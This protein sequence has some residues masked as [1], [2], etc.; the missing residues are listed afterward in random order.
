MNSR[1]HESIS[2]PVDAF[3]QMFEPHH[4]QLQTL[5]RYDRYKMPHESRETWVRLLGPDVVSADHPIL[6]AQITFQFTDY[7][8]AHGI[9]LTKD[10]KVLFFTTP[11]VHDTGEIKLEHIGVG[12]TSYDQKT[13]TDEQ[14][15]LDVFAA[16]TQSI[17]NEQTRELIHRAYYEVAMDR[18]TKLGKM[19][20]A[21][22]KIGYL[23]TAI[24]AYEGIQGERVSNWKG[25]VGNVLSNQV[26]KLL[27]Y[28][29]EYPYV[30]HMLQEHA[31]QITRML[32][33]TTDLPTV[34]LDKDGNP[35]FDRTKLIKAQLAW[36]KR[37]TSRTVYTSGVSA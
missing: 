29:N 18:N 14:V 24:R 10:E 37:D 4:K 15:E 27:D 13:Q 36:A 7:N 21:V 31:D 2:L 17:S 3:N 5:L 34:P 8:E 23:Q 19:F 16:I 6:T 1:V 9:T 33:V 35:S 20:N 28:A 11:F 32:N 25:L 12:D 30:S 22:E 26:E